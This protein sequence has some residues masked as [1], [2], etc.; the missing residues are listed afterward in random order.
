[1]CFVCEKSDKQMDCFGGDEI[2][3]SNRVILAMLL[4]LLIDAA[5]VTFSGEIFNLQTV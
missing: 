3:C 4:L 5:S 2:A 1:L